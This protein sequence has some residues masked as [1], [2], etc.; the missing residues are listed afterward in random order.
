MLRPPCWSPAEPTLPTNLPRP[1]TPGKSQL[2]PSRPALSPKEHHHVTPIHGYKEQET[3]L[4]K[5]YAVLTQK[6]M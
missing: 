2:R 4:A 3:Q 1:W 5:R 6:I